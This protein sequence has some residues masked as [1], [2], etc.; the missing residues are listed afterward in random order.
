MLRSR[1]PVA[2][3]ALIALNVGARALADEPKQTRV[4][5]RGTGQ[6][7]AIERVP[8]APRRRAA[9][10]AASPV[11]A[12]AARLAS[13]G[14]GDETVIAYLRRHQ[15]ELPQ[16]IEA[17]DV[18]HLRKS[19]AGAPV[20]AYL[21]AVAAVDLGELGEGREGS[22]APIAPQQE[23]ASLEAN[24]TPA[25]PFY[26]GYGASYVPGRSSF[27]R[28]A[29]FPHQPMFRRPMPA[30]FSSRGSMIVGRRHPQ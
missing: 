2:L 12:E 27:R 28:A 29:R 30:P 19:G 11:L 8:A 16:V 6:N 14:S 9:D 1:G 4:V 17:S 23:M 15:L 10:Q 26:G 20:L 21:E 22:Q 24:G 13:V 7:V 25:Y 3:V 5:I 18:K